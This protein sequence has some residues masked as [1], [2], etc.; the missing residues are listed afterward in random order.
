VLDQPTVPTIGAVCRW[1]R[2][3][4]HGERASILWYPS[5]PT[6]VID[7]NREALQVGSPTPK[8]R[9]GRCLAVLAARIR[10]P[11]FL[12]KPLGA[13]QNYFET[14]LFPIEVDLL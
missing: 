9:P 14:E 2:Q 6:T 10:R 12:S 13:S 3:D 5:L 4:L 11:D 7:P 1:D 8:Y